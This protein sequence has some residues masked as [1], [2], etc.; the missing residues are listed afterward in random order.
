MVQDKARELASEIRNS[1]EYK[2]YAAAKERAQANPQ[3]VEALN[4]YQQKQFELQK[5]QMLG[6]EIGGEAMEQM[7]QL[8]QILAADPLAAEYLAAQVR[9]ALMVNDVYGVLADVL[10]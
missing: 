9:F 2:N 10:K 1:E 4:D 6:E 7:Q 5:K 3:L 8:Y